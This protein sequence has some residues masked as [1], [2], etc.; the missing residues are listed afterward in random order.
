VSYRNRTAKFSY[1]QPGKFFWDSGTWDKTETD[2]TKFTIFYKWWDSGTTGIKPSIHNNKVSHQTVP[3]LRR[4]G[5]FWDKKGTAVQVS[6][7]LF[8]GREDK[9]KLAL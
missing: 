6:A 9:L 3:L 5:H 4:M 8:A 7:C 2:G 1:R